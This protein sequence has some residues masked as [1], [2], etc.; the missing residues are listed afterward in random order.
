MADTFPMVNV[1]SSNIQAVGWQAEREGD[2]VGTL[3]VAFRNG[4]VFDYSDVP[5]VIYQQLL[6]SPSVGSYFHGNI[7]SHYNSTK[8]S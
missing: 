3:R 6:E 7:K 2:D 4:A 8:V 1:S 5:G